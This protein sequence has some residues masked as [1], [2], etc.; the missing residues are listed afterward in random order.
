RVLG[1]PLGGGGSLAGKLCSTTSATATTWWSRAFP[2]ALRP[3][4]RVD[5]GHGTLPRL[6]VSARACSA[7]GV[8]GC[9][10]EAAHL[11]AARRPGRG[12][13]GDGVRRLLIDGFGRRVRKLRISVTDRCN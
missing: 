3:R 5:P 2:R 12:A 13:P 4:P 10:A 11:P 1:Q 8:A 7:G 9:R 6:A